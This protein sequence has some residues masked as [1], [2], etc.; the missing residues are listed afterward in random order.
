MAMKTSLTVLTVAFGLSTV[1]AAEAAQRIPLSAAEAQCKTQVAFDQSDIMGGGSAKNPSPRNAQRYRAC[2][3][4]KSGQ[5]PAETKKSGITIS[6]SARIGIV[7][8][9]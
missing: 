8:S 5:Y 2:V 3:F 9:D 1:S 4:A 6:G 7:V